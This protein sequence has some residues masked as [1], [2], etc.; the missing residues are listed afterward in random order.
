MHFLLRFL[1]PVSSFRTYPTG[2]PRLRRRIHKPPTS[3]HKAKGIA[4][5]GS[6]TADVAVPVTA[7][8]KPVG[9]PTL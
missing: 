8:S 5:L 7:T 9:P 3:P 6:G 1:V 2:I 4:V